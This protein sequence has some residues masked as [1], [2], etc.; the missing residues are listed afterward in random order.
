MVSPAP[1]RPSPQRRGLEQIPW[2]YD[3]LLWVLERFFGV[4]RLRRRLIAG[5]RGR[6]LD[7]GCG[8]GRNLP[9]YGGGPGGDP[10]AHRG[11]VVGVDIEAA[12]L[13]RARRRAPDVPLVRASVEALPFR[14]DAFDTV[15]S[16]LVF[17]SVGDPGA[18]L[19]ELRRV[20]RDPGE[21][22]ML[23]HVRS[24]VGWLGRLQ[25]WLQPAWTKTMGGC[26]PNRRTEA[27]VEGAGFV[28]DEGD[29]DVGV[30]MR[31]FVARKRG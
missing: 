13:L 25:D 21:L 1:P 27:V 11:L 24:D 20:V 31:R 8:T 30:I 7:V 10:G 19:S 29:R 16:G 15:V 28:L 2:L 22:R 6:V 17:C 23:E 4:G 3:L 5:A 14:S 12:S 18:G 9:L 26:H